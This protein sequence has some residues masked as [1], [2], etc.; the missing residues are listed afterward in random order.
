MA[1]QDAPVNF[2]P[3]VL[4]SEHETINKRRSSLRR[5]P[6]KQIGQTRDGKSIYD[7]VG[8][9]LSGGGIRSAAISLGVL[10][11]LDWYRTLPNIDYLSTV[12]GGG[13]IGSS[14]TATMTATN[15]W[16]VFNERV[17]PDQAEWQEDSLAVAHLRNY[18]NYLLAGGRHS[19]GSAIAIIVRGVIANATI[20]APILLYWSAAFA[21]LYFDSYLWRHYLWFWVGP[22]FVTRLLLIV[23][24]AFFLLWALILSFGSRALSAETGK[25][26][27]IAAMYLVVTAIVFFLE[28][29]PS[30]IMAVRLDSKQ[31]RF[32]VIFVS[33]LYALA[34][35]GIP[36]GLMVAVFQRHLGRALEGHWA[37]APLARLAILIAAIELPL[38][39]WIL[40]LNLS[41]I[42][43]KATD[44]WARTS[45]DREHR[46]DYPFLSN[47]DPL[48]IPIVKVSI[49]ANTPPLAL[50]ILVATVLLVCAILLK[51]NALSLHGLYRD[52]LRKA[53]LFDPS[54][55]QYD[56]FGR[57]EPTSASALRAGFR[58][59]APLDEMRVSAL[60]CEAPYQLINAAL[61]IRGSSYANQRG[62]DADFF[63][64]SPNYIGSSVTGYVPTVAFEK[65]QQGF[66][67]ATAMAISGAAVSSSMGAKSIRLLAPTLAL[68]NIRLGY[69]LRNPRRL[70]QPLPWLNFVRRSIKSLWAEVRNQL[71]TDT[72][73]EVYVTDGGHIENLGL[74]ELLRRRC[75][76]IVCV[77]AEAD[78]RMR[79]SSF[80]ALQQFASIDLGVRINLFWQPIQAATIDWM[81]YDPL[82]DKTGK[83]MMHGPHVAIGTIQ[84]GSGQTGFLFYIKSSLTGDER[85][86][87]L[88][89]AR[90]YPTFPHEATGNQFFNEEQ[91]EVYRA[92]GYH[93]VHGVLSGRDAFMW[94]DAQGTLQQS[95][96]VESDEPIIKAVRDALL[97]KT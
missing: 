36:L 6:I 63:L 59:F 19:L 91:F 78:P 33:L 84:Y 30:L 25:L 4:R 61:N 96:F 17:D 16:F 62:R 8:L 66:D 68:L 35:V 39:I 64:F 18:S 92:L 41:Y 89:Y 85:D 93:M 11:A 81:G 95:T 72:T 12:S 58:G 94:L 57:M 26:P 90:R 71:Y 60:S 87:I 80:I 65:A 79:F 74:Y 76:V 34:T 24:V 23:G 38:L 88:D 22:F 29:Q 14:M 3:D 45:Y 47:E 46:L 13:Y 56:S 21:L 44:F 52:R 9:S 70:F 28:L 51:P 55:P 67:L 5:S 27:V 82:A 97:R 73:D 32:F 53:F 31:P 77:D 42:A 43:N 48:V 2:E 83:R 75:Q 10:Q 20:V 50:Y 86:Y 49:W 54:S 15:G 1:A 69:W 40:S 7:T 37:V